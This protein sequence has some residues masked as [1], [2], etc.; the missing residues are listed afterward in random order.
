M[1]LFYVSL[2]ILVSINNFQQ[3]QHQNHHHYQQQRRTMCNSRNNSIRNMEVPFVV[4]DNKRKNKRHIT[5]QHNYHD[6]SKDCAPNLMGSLQTTTATNTTFEDLPVRGGSTAAPFP[7]KLYEMLERVEKEG[8][9][10]VVS[11]QPHGRCFAV[12]NTELFKE[13]LP[14]YFTLSKIASFQRQLNLYGFTRLTRG[15]DKGGYYQ[16]LFLRGKAF[17]LRRIQRV[18]VKGTGVRARSNP[19]QE[20]DFWTM[21]WVG[22]EQEHSAS[23]SAH[24]ITSLV[25]ASNITSTSSDNYSVV[26]HDDMDASSTSAFSRPVSPPLEQVTS[27]SARH[28]CPSLIAPVQVQPLS[29]DFD[30]DSSSDDDDLVMTG[31]GKP[32][33]FLDSL[34]GEVEPATAAPVKS[35][36]FSSKSTPSNSARS[37]VPLPEDEQAIGSVMDDFMD[38]DLDQLVNEIALDQANQDE[39]SFLQLLERIIE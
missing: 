33:F 18:K 25:S 24:H 23:L 21:P 37:A 19:E 27:C 32:F 22:Q 38:L 30:E 36:V 5:V 26:S 17:L 20:P 28:Q 2:S 11:W 15:N 29:F 12:H 6:H 1:Q 34:P 13:L 3:Q 14:R 31:W 16:E 10:H 4:G 9:G 39:E 35:S 7:V 8:F